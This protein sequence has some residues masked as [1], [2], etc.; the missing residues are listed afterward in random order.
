MSNGLIPYKL[1]RN[2]IHLLHKVVTNIVV[3]R[4]SIYVMF[5]FLIIHIIV[6]IKLHVCARDLGEIYILFSTLLKVLV[7]R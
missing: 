6:V 2:L 1:E 7:V 4:F 5:A 3:F